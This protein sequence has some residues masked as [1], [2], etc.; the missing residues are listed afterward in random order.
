MN[1]ESI[2]FTSSAT[3]QG[4]TS[5][6]GTA[7]VNVTGGS[8]G[9]SYSWA[10]LPIQT[11]QTASNLAFGSYTCNISDVNLS[12]YDVLK[13]DNYNYDVILA[14][15]NKNILLSLLPKLCDSKATIVLSGLL[16]SDKED[17]KDDTVYPTKIRISPNKTK[18]IDALP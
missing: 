4:C 17:V 8:P 16:F 9:Y 12:I 7:T 2:V 14:N 13:L 6:D 3:A 10:T 5:L 15:I 11:T 18:N 1:N